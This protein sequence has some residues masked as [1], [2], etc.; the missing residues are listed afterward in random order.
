MS[1]K[2]EN[3]VETSA[4]NEIMKVNYDERKYET[5]KDINRLGNL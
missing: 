2:V 4:L 1:I 5:T 3:A